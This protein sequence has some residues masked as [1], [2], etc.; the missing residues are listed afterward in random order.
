MPRHGSVTL[1]D[2][3]GRLEMLRIECAKCG[4]AGQYR[5]MRLMKECGPDTLLPELL[6]LISADCPKRQA[7]LTSDP[8][9]AMMPDLVRP[10]A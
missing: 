8:C 7:R 4:R 3:A 5:V 9:K 1:G 10:P 6:A 2:I